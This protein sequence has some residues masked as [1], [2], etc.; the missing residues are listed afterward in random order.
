M[1]RLKRVVCE[2]RQRF[3][4]GL[5]EERALHQRVVCQAVAAA[6]HNHF[7]DRHRRNCRGGRGFRRT[8]RCRADYGVYDAAD[9]LRA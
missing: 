2:S 6:R 9:V 7:L 4:L 1:H 8:G 5:R 3:E